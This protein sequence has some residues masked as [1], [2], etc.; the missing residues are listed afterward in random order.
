M[1]SNAGRNFNGEIFAV[2]DYL[3]GILLHEC[4]KQS[5]N[6]CHMQQSHQI[7]SRHSSNLST[8]SHIIAKEN[9]QEVIEIFFGI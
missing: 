7:V 2:G 1:H 8:R 3:G 5:G 9:G 6:H 4:L